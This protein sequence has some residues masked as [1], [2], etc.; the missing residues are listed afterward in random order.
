M[1]YVEGESITDY[2]DA[3]RL[4]G[5]QQFLGAGVEG[6]TDHQQQGEQQAD[7][8][9]RGSRH[10]DALQ[11]LKEDGGFC[12]LFSCFMAKDPARSVHPVLIFLIRSFPL[13][14]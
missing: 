4:A 14:L 7:G 5:S 1:E 10:D 9:F 2:C 8:V 12:I 3:Q 11:S 13:R 6:E